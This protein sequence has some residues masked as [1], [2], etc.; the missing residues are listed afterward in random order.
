M[1]LATDDLNSRVAAYFG[2]ADD[3][4]PTRWTPERVMERLVEAFTVIMN[5]AGRIGP[6][7]HGVAW[8]SILR[9]FS[10]YV[11]YDKVQYERDKR[12]EIERNADRAVSSAELSRAEEAIGW[13][14]QYLQ[15]DPV[16]AD[17]LQLWALCKARHIKIERVLRARCLAAEKL[18]V[19]TNRAAD[20]AHFDKV[21]ARRRDIARKYAQWAN[22]RLGKSTGARYDAR[23]RAGAAE[24]ARRE[25][26]KAER[27]DPR[28][29]SK[30]RRSEVMPGRVFTNQWLDRKRKEGAAAVAAALDGD[31]VVVR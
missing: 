27:A 7:A 13:A 14:S 20:A 19:A 24:L 5:T 8:P 21:Q 16:L 18:M 10:D 3:G 6:K 1:E 31:G 17:A 26:I 25:I 9:E 28:P 2:A 4:L 12:A 11:G 15:A 22:D 29:S 23:I 30:M